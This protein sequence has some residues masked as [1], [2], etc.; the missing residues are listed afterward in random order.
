VWIGMVCTL[1][2]VLNPATSLPG[3]FKVTH[4]VFPLPGYWKSVKK[5]V[6][7][8]RTMTGRLWLETAPFAIIG[9]T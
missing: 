3:F 7:Q 4:E 9:F 5:H 2:Y 6:I 8:P 1:L